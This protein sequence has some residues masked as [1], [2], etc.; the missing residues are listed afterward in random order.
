MNRQLFLNKYKMADQDV[1]DMLTAWGLETYVD[2]FKGKLLKV[3]YFISI[4]CAYF[5]TNTY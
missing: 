2:I 4:A 3:N 5:N 1:T